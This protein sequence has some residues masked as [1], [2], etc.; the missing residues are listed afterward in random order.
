MEYLQVIA[1]LVLLVY[2]GKYLVNGG[3]S[4]AKSFH[5]STLVVGITV[6][7]FGTSA[8]ELIVSLNAAI[9]GHSEIAIGNVVGSNI[10]NIGFI[11]ALTAII[12]PISVNRL[13]LISDWPIMM[14]AGL[15]L[16]AFLYNNVISVLEG[17]ILLVFLVLFVLWTIRLSK[18]NPEVFKEEKE[19][20][21]PQYRIPIAIGIVIAASAGLALGA[22]FLVNGSTKIALNFG[23]SE[24]IISITVVAVGTSI[25]ELTASIIAAFKKQPDISLGNVVG[26]NIFNIFGVIG[27]SATISPIN[28]SHDIFNFDIIVM[29]LISIVLFLFIFPFKTVYLRRYEGISLLLI[30][31][32]YIYLVI[33]GNSEKIL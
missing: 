10:A 21:A 2:S 26:S 30:Y 23:I 18:K 19:I 29:L 24:R 1:G 15:L 33:S 5:V 22:D 25:P 28:I 32:G 7:A 8:P 6:V 3:V 4:L 20:E 11:L 17:I 16:Y 9:S 13:S 27:I 31:I 12:I 14:F